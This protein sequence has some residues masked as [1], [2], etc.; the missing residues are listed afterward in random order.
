MSSRTAAGGGG[1]FPRMRELA[2]AGRPGVEDLEI[3]LR[4]CVEDWLQKGGEA[5]AEVD[6]TV[7]F[8]RK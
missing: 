4:N 7:G 1:R 5:C 3:G 6:S 2:T 8:R